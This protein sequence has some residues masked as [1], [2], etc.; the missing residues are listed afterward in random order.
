[1]SQQTTTSCPTPEACDLPDGWTVATDK[2]THLSVLNQDTRRSIAAFPTPD[3]RGWT[4]MGVGGYGPDCPVLAK[5]VTESV[6]LRVLQREAAAV[7]DGQ[8]STYSPDDVH[9]YKHCANCGRQFARHPNL[10][11]PC[12]SCGVDIGHPCERPSGHNGPFV[13][14]HLDRGRKAVAEGV[15]LACPDGPTGAPKIVRERCERELSAN[16][17]ATTATEATEERDSDDGGPTQ[18][19][20]D[21]WDA[22]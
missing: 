2:P 14:Y 19:T 15:L 18:S 22:P 16:T 17:T 6:A 7:A 9:D 12:P 5:G 20:L 13:D 11:V 21:A 8:P 4:V 10:E 3:R 1:M